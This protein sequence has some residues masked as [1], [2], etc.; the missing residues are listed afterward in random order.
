[1]QNPF[2]LPESFLENFEIYQTPFY[3]NWLVFSDCHVPY[4]DIPA[5]TELLNYGIGKG[6]D[7]IYLN[8]DVLDFYEVS[9]FAHDTSKMSLRD[10]IEHGKAFLDAIQ[11]ATGA[12]IFFKAGNHEARLEYHIKRKTPELLGFDCLYIDKLLGLEERG[13]SYIKEN[14]LALIGKLPI[15][16]GHELKLKS[17]LV[18]PA[19]SLFLKTFHS[20]MCGHLHVPS[21]HNEKDLNGKTISTWSLGHTGDSHP[22]YAPFNRWV[23]GGA[24]VE[25]DENGDFEVINLRLIGNKIHRT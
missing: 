9:V 4:H 24:R 13:I 17:I 10:E 20:C 6:I 5:I 25:T 21:Q 11:K 8:G 16:H 23:H 14:Q 22:E 2:N 12:K 15:V 3:K 1:M 7:A 19:R 18:N